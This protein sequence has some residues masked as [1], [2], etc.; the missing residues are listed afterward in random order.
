MT[1]FA[2]H[3]APKLIAPGKLASGERVVFHRVG[4]HS[5]LNPEPCMQIKVVEEAEGHTALAKAQATPNPKPYTLK[6]KP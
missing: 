2:P 6:P 3:L 1:K 4:T 5:L